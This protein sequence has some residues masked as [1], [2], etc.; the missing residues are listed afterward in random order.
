M[1]RTDDLQYRGLVLLQDTELPCFTEDSVW[2][3]NFL[4]LRGRD[5]VIDLGSGS[6]LLSVL[7][8]GK[9]G[10]SFVGVEKHAALVALAK[11]SAAVNGQEIPFYAMD[12]ADAPAFFGHGSFTAAVI[13]PPYFTAGPASTEEHRAAARHGDADTLSTFFHAAFLLLN[14]GG[15][16]FVCY[17]AER[18]CDLFAALR[19]ARLEPK[20]AKLVAAS[21]EKPPRLILLEA[22]KDAKPGIR[23]EPTAVGTAGS[24]TE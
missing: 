1:R 4:R 5:R 8:Q 24:D 18:M 6:G 22:Q 11:E 7:G 3:A 19:A 20:R 17:P 15:K 16:L 2:L 13:N 14:N 23:W 10:A 21:F 12:V 9:T